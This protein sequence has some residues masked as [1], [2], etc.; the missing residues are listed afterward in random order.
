VIKIKRIYVN[1]ILFAGSTCIEQSCR[2]LYVALLMKIYFTQIMG[3]FC[4]FSVVWCIWRYI[5]CSVGRSAALLKELVSSSLLM[6]SMKCNGFVII[7]MQ[8]II[9]R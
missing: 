5:L 1:K 9:K 2:K 7:N 6:D 8:S 3:S 4:G